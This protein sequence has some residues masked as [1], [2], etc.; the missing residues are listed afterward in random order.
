MNK[1]TRARNPG[2]QRF[3]ACVAFYQGMLQACCLRTR[4]GE[5]GKCEFQMIE[6]KK[7]ATDNAD[8]KKDTS[9]G[10]SPEWRKARTRRM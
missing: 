5:I 9:K 4:N 2:C 10:L 1:P 3:L 8:E 6:N 7:K